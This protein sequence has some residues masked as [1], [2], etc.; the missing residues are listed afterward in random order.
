MQTHA[1]KYENVDPEFGR[2]VKKHFYVD[3]INNTARST[4]EGF[5]IYIKIK[6]KFSEVS[7]NIRKWRTKN[8]EWRKLI[9]DYENRE[10]I[11]IERHVNNEVPKYV[12]VVNSFN[13]KK[14]LGPYWDH[15]R[16]VISLKI[17]DKNYF[18]RNMHVK[19]KIV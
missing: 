12:N 13:N 3:D 11:N 8:P 4:K 17:S 5:E 15:Q 14:V 10:V 2:K 16:D 6:S 18:P 7:F 1:N 19:Y 9:H